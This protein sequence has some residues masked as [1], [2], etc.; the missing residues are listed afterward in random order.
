MKNKYLFL[1]PG[2]YKTFSYTYNATEKNKNLELNED[3]K[4]I[5]RSI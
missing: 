1:I 3:Q 4:P 5:S 2:V